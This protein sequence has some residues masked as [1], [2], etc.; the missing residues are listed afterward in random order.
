MNKY[1]GSEKQSLKTIEEI[2]NEGQIDKMIDRLPQNIFETGVNC[3]QYRSFKMS[4]EFHLDPDTVMNEQVRMGYHMFMVITGLE[5]KT[6]DYKFCLVDQGWFM[7]NYPSLSL[8][9]E[10]TIAKGTSSD[11]IANSKIWTQR[12]NI[13]Y[14]WTVDNSLPKRESTYSFFSFNMDTKEEILLKVHTE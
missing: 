13:M 14:Y 10:K 6:R 3:K 5:E 7:M 9:C 4:E 2:I 11:T 12:N 8:I 1:L